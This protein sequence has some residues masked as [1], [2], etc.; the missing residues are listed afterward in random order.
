[1]KGLWWENGNI[2]CMLGK[3]DHFRSYFIKYC[4]KKRRM[5]WWKWWKGDNDWSHT[6]YADVS[7]R[8]N[9]FIFMRYLRHLKWDKIS[10]VNLYTYEPPFQKSWIRPCLLAHLKWANLQ[11]VFRTKCINTNY[12]LVLSWSIVRAILCFLFLFLLHYTTRKKSSCK[13]KQLEHISSTLTLLNWKDRHTQKN[14]NYKF[15]AY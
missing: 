10:E 13:R 2:I 11:V 4:F 15:F 5:N 1:M 12:T 9:Y 6:Y 7:V 8:P 3:W 14:G